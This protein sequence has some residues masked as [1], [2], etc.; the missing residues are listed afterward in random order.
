MRNRWFVVLFLCSA[1]TALAQDPEFT[2]SVG[3]RAWFTEWTTFSYLTDEAVPPNRLGL[4]EISADPEV[5]FI[6]LLSARYGKFMAS[7]SGITSTDYTH[8]DGNEGSREE[9]DIN[10]G[11]Y[12]LPTVAITAGYK[13][14]QQTGED[15]SPDGVGIYRPSGLVVGISG[16]API[17][18]P[19]SL[20]GNLSL[21]KLETPSGDEIDFDMDYRLTEIGIAYTMQ[22]K[23]KPKHWTFTAGYRM[24]VMNSKDAFEAAEGSQDGLDTTQGFSLG[25]VATF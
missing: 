12:V 23:S 14:V 13:K 4:V 24:Q 22:G 9:F 18:G 3:A 7:V 19:W 20:Y 2:V 21:G 15:D 6:P 5:A 10:V 16:S 8:K 1:Q 17:H 25:V 11:Y